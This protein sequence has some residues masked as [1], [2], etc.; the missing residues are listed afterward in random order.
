MAPKSAWP[1]CRA[2]SMAERQTGHRAPPQRPPCP[3][4]NISPPSRYCAALSTASATPNTR[5]CDRP[6]SSKVCQERTK[7]GTR[8]THGCTRPLDRVKS[9]ILEVNLRCNTSYPSVGIPK[10][11]ANSMLVQP[12]AA[13]LGSMASRRF[14]PSPTLATHLSRTLTRHRRARRLCATRSICLMTWRSKYAE[15]TEIG[16]VRLCDCK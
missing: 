12:A 4:A 11:V 14:A 16:M 5:N 9:F 13:D 10:H 15:N 2:E 6:S 8:C 1:K 3:K 7:R